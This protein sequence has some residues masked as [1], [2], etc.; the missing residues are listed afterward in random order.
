M[1]L[2]TVLRNKH[3]VSAELEVQAL[4]CLTYSHEKYI[5]KGYFNKGDC[6]M[7]KTVK[8]RLK[9][10]EAERFA[11]TQEQGLTQ[12]VCGDL[13]KHA[14]SVNDSIGD[15]GIRNMNILVCV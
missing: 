9:A 1:R 12:A 13:E 10:E 15:N 6:G 7:K 3:G 14:Y 5:M 4:H 8:E 2:F 11:V